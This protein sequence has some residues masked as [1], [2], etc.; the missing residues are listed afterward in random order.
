MN[1]RFTTLLLSLFASSTFIY[2]KINK[3]DELNAEIEEVVVVAYGTEKKSSLIGSSESIKSNKIQ[4]RSI[5][6]VTSAFLGNIAGVQS[7]LSDGQ[8]GSA[9]SLSIR[10]FALGMYSGRDTV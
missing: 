3:E 8:P 1:L 9:P 4:M 10:G 6:S 2:S 5:S 7:T